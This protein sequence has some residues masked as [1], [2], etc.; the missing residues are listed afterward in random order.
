MGL[1]DSTGKSTDL[2]KMNRS[3]GYLQQQMFDF[4]KRHPGHHYVPADAE[5]VRIARSLEKRG[6]LHITDCGMVDARARPVLMAC[7]IES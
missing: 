3:L 5:S 2:K 7:Y 4:C 6:L 1:P